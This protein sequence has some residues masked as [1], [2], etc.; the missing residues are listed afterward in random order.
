MGVVWWLW[1][2]WFAQTRRSCLYALRL[3]TVMRRKV[4]HRALAIAGYVEPWTGTS[5][6]RRLSMSTSAE[7]TSVGIR[8]LDRDGM[9]AMDWQ[10]RQ[11]SVA[12]HREFS[13]GA[14][15][16]ISRFENLGAIRSLSFELLVTENAGQR[17]LLDCG[18][19]LAM[20][21]G[22]PAPPAARRGADVARTAPGKAVAGVRDRLGWPRGTHQSTR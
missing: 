6:V 19:L 1:K 12:A 3:E 13:Q 5:S 9:P 11:L 16:E 21:R 8:R 14:F 22:R 18:R 2:P 15:A 10:V 7:I 20:D 4:E 17:V